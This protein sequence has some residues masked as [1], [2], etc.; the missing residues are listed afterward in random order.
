MKQTAYV[1]KDKCF[2]TISTVNIS[3][4]ML[5]YS[6]YKWNLQK[7][8]KI[9]N[10]MIVTSSKLEQNWLKY[11]H[12]KLR[13][14]RLIF[15]LLPVQQMA[16][17]D[18]TKTEEL[19][20]CLIMGNWFQFPQNCPF[21]FLKTDTSS[22]KPR[23]LKKAGFW[24]WFQETVHLFIISCKCTGIWSIILFVNR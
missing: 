11:D 19:W 24:V 17:V 6:Q 20:P 5:Y 9:M 4:W 8:L 3:N 15:Q 22:W 14:D 18:Y 13:S 12:L 23:N 10:N 2:G 1:S 16:A 7:E 21:Y